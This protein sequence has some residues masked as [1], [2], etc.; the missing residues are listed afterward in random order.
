[1]KSMTY[2]WPG[3]IRE[4]QNLVER[5]V[6]V[7][8]SGTLTIDEQWLSGP[9]SK[10]RPRLS[11]QLRT[12]DMQEKEAIEA[13]LLECKGRVSGPFGAARLLGLPSSTLESKIKALNIDKRRFKTAESN[14]SLNNSGGRQP[15]PRGFRDDS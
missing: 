2:D 8:D 3:N 15:N 5:A 11:P 4:L 9:S 7:C 14:G 10:P 6:I 1:M 12:L 13:A